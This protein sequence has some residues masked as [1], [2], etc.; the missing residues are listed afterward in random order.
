[1]VL[2]LVLVCQH[3]RGVLV[4][5]QAYT[6]RVAVSRSNLGPEQF[7]VHYLHEASLKNAVHS[8]AVT[9]QW[10]FFFFH[11]LCKTLLHI[12]ITTH[13]YIRTTCSFQFVFVGGFGCHSH[14]PS[15]IHLHRR[16]TQNLTTFNSPNWTHCNNTHWVPL[17]SAS[18]KGFLKSS[19]I[20][21]CLKKTSRLPRAAEKTRPRSN[22]HVEIK[23][24][25]DVLAK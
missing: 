15:E 13:A 22:N 4:I 23:V 18:V 19:L 5:V 21:T 9:S 2:S 12:Q 20:Y 7:S 16:P 3:S 1:M 14:T 6:Q 17:F 24:A 10:V 8:A 11:C 25:N